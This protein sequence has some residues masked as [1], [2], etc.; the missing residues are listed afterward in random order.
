MKIEIK[1][2]GVVGY[3]LI[4]GSLGLAL[5][6]Y[7]DNHI[8]AIDKNK[9]TLEYIKNNKLYY[10]TATNVETGKSE[11]F[12]N[13]STIPFILSG[14]NEQLSPTADAPAAF[15]ETATAEGVLPF[16]VVPFSSKERVT[17]TDRF[18][19]S[20]AAKRAILASLKS[21]KVSRQ[22]ISAPAFSPHMQTSL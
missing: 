11:Y 4:G 17:V 18:V 1:T 14:P 16:I 15:K 20:F 7:T 3:G 2:I 22:I 19:F 6:K 13:S 10:A 21:V 8:I 12:K 9:E 5:K